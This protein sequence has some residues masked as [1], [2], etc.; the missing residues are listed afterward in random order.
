[1]IFLSETSTQDNNTFQMLNPESQLI[2]CIAAT[3][4]NYCDTEAN[5][6]LQGVDCSLGHQ[7]ATCCQQYPGSINMP[8][9]YSTVKRG[10]ARTVPHVHIPAA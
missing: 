3:Y 10:E 2:N 6:L 8:T 5:L 1:M 7:T 4:F 9:M